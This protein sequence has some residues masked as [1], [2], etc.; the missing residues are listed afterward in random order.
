MDHKRQLNIASFNCKHFKDKGPKLDFIQNLMSHNDILFLQEHCLF[1]SQLYKLK[2]LDNVEIVGKSSMN[3]NTI[4]RGRP[5]GGCAILYNSNMACE[6]VEIKCRSDRL[7]AILLNFSD[8]NNILLFNVYMPCD[9][10]IVDKVF[11]NVLNEIE[12]TVHKINPLHVIVG[13]DFN[14]DFSRS[15]STYHSR[16][17]RE[18]IQAQDMTVCID[19]DIATVP[20]TF[21][22]PNSTSRIDHFLVSSALSKSIACCGIIDDVLHSDHCPL[23]VCFDINIDYFECRERSFS[24]KYCWEKADHNVINEY[25]QRLDE[26]LG[27][28]Q[29]DKSMLTC[30]DNKCKVHVDGIVKLYCDII[31]ACKSASDQCIPRTKAVKHGPGREYGEGSQRIPGWNDYVE[32]LRKEA[33][34]WHYEWKACGR[35]HNG[36]IAEHRRLS[37]AQ[38]HR[39]VK[40]VIRESDMVKMEKMAEALSKNNYRDLWKEVKKI[41]GRNRTCTNCIDG[42]SD[43]ADIC[44]VFQNKYEELYNCVHYDVQ[45]VEDLKREIDA[46]LNHQLNSDFV[47]CINDVKEAIANLKLGK[48]D[49]EE[50]LVSD[51]FINGTMQLQ[52]LIT[53]LFNCMLVHGV[54]PDTMSCGTMI[55]TGKVALWKSMKLTKNISD[56]F[57]FFNS[58]LAHI[59]SYVGGICMPNFTPKYLVIFILWPIMC[60]NLTIWSLI[61]VLTISIKMAK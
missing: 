2:C 28:L 35:P 34:L 19:L 3:E 14:T 42:H 31:R 48:S 44:D 52:V 47:I 22:G 40:K 24:S 13:G 30:T 4:L 18:F 16:V 11:N 53:C 46:E 61:Q 59:Q 6:C 37:R 7:C 39:A 38:Y 27:S 36:I 20:Y 15:R 10:G 23:L 33:L 21:V 60:V 8:A 32:P 55:F 49:G 25:K 50:G 1:S 12:Q 45:E 58:F 43:D 5:F 9:T 57:H 56:D 26:I 17:L 54:C 51:H 41:K 29:Y